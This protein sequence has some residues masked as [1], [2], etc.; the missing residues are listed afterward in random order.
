MTNTY[1]P[2]FIKA[3]QAR[4]ARVAITASAT[5]G[6]K[7]PGLVAN[8]RGFCAALDLRPFATS[9]RI[10]FEHR[11]DDCTNYLLSALPR[12]ARHWGVSRKLL[13]IFLRDALYTR[14]LCEHFGLDIAEQF[15][16][17]PLDS[18]SG[19]QCYRIDGGATL[20]PWPGVKYL[21][22]KT[23]AQYQV[24]VRHEATRRRVAPIHLDTFWWGERS[25]E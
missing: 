2:S 23:S 25:S 19:K 14:Y 1:T 16:E 21:E 12:R 11:L 10:E 9:N 22:R 6:Q 8:A 18:I 4:T 24:V 5:R 13:N 3:V 17:V 7:A 20:P 15:F